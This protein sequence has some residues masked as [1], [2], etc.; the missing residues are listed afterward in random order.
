M[1]R[2]CNIE[3]QHFMAAIVGRE[4][5]GKSLT[6]LKIAESADPTFNASRVMFEP[7]AFLER[8]REWKAAGE[9]KGKLVVADE[10]GVGLGVRTWYQKDQILFNQVLQVIRDENMGIIFTLP[11]LS[12]LDSQ[13][14]G[15]LHAFLEMKDKEDGEWADVKWLNWDPTRDERDKVYRHYPEMKINGYTRKVKALRL[16]PPSEDLVKNYEKRKEAFQ[17][18]LYQDAIDEMDENEE[19]T[20]SPSEVADDIA[21]SGVK[22]YVS[23]HG[24]NKTK[25]IDAELIEMDYDLSARNAK[26][27]K[28]LLDRDDDISL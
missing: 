8:L 15:R 12:E 7:K 26:K 2:A 20:M 16:T 11:R 17:D 28:K 21:E 3:N 22:D 10:A 27:V 4:G 25:Y 9:T 23:I 18:Q 13:A 14:R 19:Q 5:S 6:G 1:W 24:G